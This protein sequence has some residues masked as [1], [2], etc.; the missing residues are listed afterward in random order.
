MSGYT[1]LV[2]R[3]GK[4]WP[5]PGIWRTLEVMERELTDFFP[6]SLPVAPGHSVPITHAADFRE[7]DIPKEFITC[8]KH[9]FVRV[10]FKGSHGEKLAILD[11]NADFGTS[12]VTLDW[13]SVVQL[14]PTCVLKRLLGALAAALEADWGAVRDDDTPV[15][16]DIR[17][18]SFTIDKASVPNALYWMNWFGPAQLRVIGSDR[19]KRLAPF[20]EVELRPPD[21]AFVIL[22]QESFSDA[23]PV[24]VRRRE[25]AEATLGLAELHRQHPQR[26][27]GTRNVRR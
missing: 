7:V 16:H 18:R 21:G 10:P 3:Y 26:V 19:L 12:V 17:E 20:A 9:P 2:H 13:A 6:A 15:R 11:Q 4:A 1:L 14:P 23:N 27:D 5:A 24:H 25:E 22:Q 8:G